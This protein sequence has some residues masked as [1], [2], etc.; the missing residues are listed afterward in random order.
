MN[1]VSMT[2]HSFLIHDLSRE[3]ISAHYPHETDYHPIVWDHVKRQPARATGDTT[4][5]TSSGIPFASQSGSPLVTPYV[6][7][8]IEATFRELTARR[9]NPSLANIQ[10]AVRRT[11]EVFGAPGKL[12]EELAEDLSYRLH[13]LFEQGAM[14][15]D[16]SYPT[17]KDGLDSAKSESPDQSDQLYIKRYVNGQARK[18]GLFPRRVRT[19]N[20]RNINY[21]IVVDEYVRELLLRYDRNEKPDE[22]PNIVEFD[23]VDPV[24][25]MMLWLVMEKFGLGVSYVEIE[26]RLGLEKDKQDNAIHQAK[27]SLGKLLG[28]KLHRNLF[29]KT[30]GRRYPIR[31]QGMNF[32]WMRLSADPLESELIYRSG[33]P[34]E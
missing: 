10:D 2:S 23:E 21:D 20:R 27:T 25:A 30:S 22:P 13:E 18:C 5:D 29:G 32:C 6:I 28:E 4:C 26:L 17:E 16:D 15:V 7:T 31:R 24:A 34:S 1:V 12:I 9:Q 14:E 11:A 3:F 19:E 33:H 8:T